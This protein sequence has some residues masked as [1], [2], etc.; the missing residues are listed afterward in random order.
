MERSTIQFIEVELQGQGIR[1]IATGKITEFLQRVE[2]FVRVNSL[3]PVPVKYYKTESDRMATVNNVAEILS[4]VAFGLMFY[5][6]MK[7]NG[8]G[9]M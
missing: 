4:L 8:A 9:A 5:R 2:S 7:R 1:K 6:L 3:N